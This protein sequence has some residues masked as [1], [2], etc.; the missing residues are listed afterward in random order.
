MHF[1]DGMRLL[2]ELKKALIDAPGKFP[3]HGNTAY[4]RIYEETADYLNRHVHPNVV[5][6]ATLA[7]GN[8]FLTDHGPEHIK[9]VTMRADD[10]LLKTEVAFGSK[11]AINPYE[12]FLLLMAI[13]FHDVGNMYGREGHE[14]RILDCMNKVSTLGGINQWEKTT[15]AKIARAHGG[16]FHGDKDTIG[17]SM[18]KGSSS[19]GETKCRPQPLAAILRLADELS[20]DASRADQYGMLTGTVPPESGV[21]H[22]FAKALNSLEIDHEDQRIKMHFFLQKDQITETFGKGKDA[23]GTLKRAYLFDEILSRSRKT[24]CE[25]IYCN[26]FLRDFPVKLHA[27]EVLV[28]AFKNENSYDPFESHKYILQER[29]YPGALEHLSFEEL[30]DA[31]DNASGQSLKEHYELE[32]VS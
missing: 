7:D 15:I 31:F 5:A 1:H 10:M 30:C 20:E 26:K 27:I 14:Q 23:Q 32:V 12:V 16:I 4:A 22:A 8:G 11:N 19:I 25:L 28:E 17:L 29:G 3:G 24:F 9:M 2:D 18:Q 6:H 21:Y 13:H